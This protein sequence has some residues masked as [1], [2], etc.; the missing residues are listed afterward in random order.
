[1]LVRLVALSSESTRVPSCM[2]EDRIGRLYL[3]DADSEQLEPLERVDA[4]MLMQW[5]E[6]SQ[7]CAWRPAADLVQRLKSSWLSGPG[8]APA[9]G[10]ATVHLHS[11]QAASAR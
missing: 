5:F 7:C 9:A 11:T 8:S 6:S 2:L 4:D 1:M 10:L 3:L